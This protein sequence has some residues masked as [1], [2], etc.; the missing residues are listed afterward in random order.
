[1]QK[2]IYNLLLLFSIIF[3]PQFVHAD[4]RVLDVEKNNINTIIENQVR[5]KFS[6]SGLAT[7]YNGMTAYIINENGI[8]RLS[9]D[10]FYDL[11]ANQSLAVV[12][13]FKILTVTNINATIS[14]T[15]EKLIFKE[16]SNREKIQ[17]HLFL[18]SD[19]IQLPKL[20]QKLRYAHL[21]Q[22][23]RVLC[24]WIEEI[25][26]WFHSLHSMGWGVTIILFSLLFKIFILPVNILLTQSQRKVSQIKAH[27]ATELEMIKK[28]YTGEEA[29]DK[30]IAAHKAQ[31]VTPFYNLKPLFLTLA[32][33]PFWIA[34]FNVLG[35][36]DLIAGH[37]FMWI[38]DL[39]YPDAF[40][41]LGLNIPLLGNSI[42]L[43][44]ILM[45]LLTIF[46]A[47]LHENKIVSKKELYKQKFNLYFMALGCMLLFY[48]FPAAMVLY[49]TL[50]NLW[51]L[52]QQRF[53]HV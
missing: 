53:I 27:L 5:E 23:L 8:E 20:F 21:W 47:I 41:K 4:V 36:S 2:Y 10:N 52:I 29:H 3:F 7:F 24:I 48:P 9:G 13:H 49:W 43:L 22:P 35:E 44:P 45:T 32:P 6:Y 37:S 39:S 12:G 14:F 46:A 19:L 30:F 42:N 1:M 34:I 16:D 25:L 15:D 17:A 28:N 11:T 33:I 38:S 18:K 40:F 50:A 31:G 26:L 51:S